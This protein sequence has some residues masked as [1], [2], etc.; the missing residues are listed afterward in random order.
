MVWPVLE[1]KSGNLRAARVQAATSLYHEVKAACVKAK[2]LGTRTA[3]LAYWL[4]PD[5]RAA[6]EV[7]SAELSATLPQLFGGRPA[8]TMET[9]AG[10]SLIE[11][12][13]Q[14]LSQG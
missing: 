10:E 2:F 12:E 5:G 1:S 8:L 11:A 13:I 4:L 14:A 9:I 3:F 6:A 7:T